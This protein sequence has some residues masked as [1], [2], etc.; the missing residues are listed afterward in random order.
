MWA[1]PLSESRFCSGVFS[2]CNGKG[3]EGELSCAQDILEGPG[4]VLRQEFRMWV[5]A[6]LEWFTAVFRGQVE[7]VGENNQQNNSVEM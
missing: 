5:N 6:H 4:S 1:L 3:P 2:W 7:A